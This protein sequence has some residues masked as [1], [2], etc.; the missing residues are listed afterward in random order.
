M[1]GNN[2]RPNRE[3][4][5]EARQ[6][7]TGCSDTCRGLSIRTSAVVELTGHIRAAEA[8]A[9]NWQIAPL[10][11]QHRLH[12]D[13]THGIRSDIVDAIDHRQRHRIRVVHVRSEGA[14]LAPAPVRSS[15]DGIPPI[16][17]HG[18]YDDR[19]W[20]RSW[21]RPIFHAGGRLVRPARW[22]ALH[23]SLPE[24]KHGAMDA[25]KSLPRPWAAHVIPSL[26]GETGSPRGPP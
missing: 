19:R 14:P 9:D 21:S 20:D 3:M 17:W 1:E 22:L 24:G 16:Y 26:F 18:Q 4:N 12:D 8:G 5:P 10:R 15:F 2:H 25:T 13:G 6:A 11:I 7:V 23:F